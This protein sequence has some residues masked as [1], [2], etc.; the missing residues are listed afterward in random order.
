MKKLI[1]AL[2]ISLMCLNV[3]AQGISDLDFLIGKW[4]VQETI[5][6]GTE[7]SWTEAGVRTCEYYLKGQFI[8]CES[9]TT[10]S[11]NQRERAYTYL[12]NYN[13]K[14][15]YFEVTS[16][17]HDFPLHGQHQWYLD[18]ERKVIQAISPVNVIEDRFFRGTIDYSDSNRIVWNGWSS[19]YNEDKEWKQVFN[20][21]ATKKED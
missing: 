9:L 11:R 1:V 3:T 8:K 10:D 12:I 18:K 20:D 14:A 21:I 2:S 4:E 17:A 16:L 7:N 15:K 6:P 5:Y 19:K 13:E